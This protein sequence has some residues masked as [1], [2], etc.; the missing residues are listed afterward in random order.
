M[1]V[2]IAAIGEH[3]NVFL[4]SDRMITTG[5]I[6][7]EPQQP[8][9]WQI[10]TSIAVMTAGDMAL[11][12][13]ILH[14]VRA[15]VQR[16]IDAEP[17]N[18]WKISD[19]TDLYARAYFRARSKRAERAILF[20]LGLDQ[21]SYIAK[22]QQL[23]AQLNA[24]IA[25]DLINF[26]IPSVEAII[27]GIDNLGA[28]IFIVR[29]GEKSCHD[30]IGF[31]TIGIGAGH[32]ASHFMFQGHTRSRPVPETMFRTFAAKKR[33]EVAPGVGAETDM[34]IIGPQLGNYF[35]VYP[36]VI[37]RLDGIYQIA[38]LNHQTADSSANLAMDQYVQE[39]I[40]ATSTAQIQQ[41]APASD[42]DGTLPPNKEADGTGAV[43]PTKKDPPDKG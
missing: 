9:I 16:R 40:K 38:R 14:D 39:V 41:E 28:H 34:V 8:K 18:W 30:N 27:T 29:D 19:V 15:D 11:Q 7:F 1:T 10:T 4:A 2:C 22:S 37:E 26:E 25:S 6:E 36:N 23:P 33:A 12:T 35:L 32:A 17:K 3:N 43:S 20:P 31:A 21:N 13:E 42:S 5:D 24:R